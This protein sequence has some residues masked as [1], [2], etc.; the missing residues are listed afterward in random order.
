M[1]ANKKSKKPVKKS[2]KPV[3][4]TR[5][6]AKGKVQKTPAKGSAKTAKVSESQELKVRKLKPSRYQSFKMS[7]RIKHQSKPLPSAFKLL[8]STFKQ[9]IKNWRLFGGITLIYI[10]LNI[11]LVKSLGTGNNISELKGTLQSAFSGSAANIKTSLTLF[12]TLLSNVGSSDSSATSTYQTIVLLI[13]S[14]VLIWALRQ[15]TTEKKHVPSVRDAFY[16][17]LYPLVPFVLVIIVIELQFIPLLIANFLG[18]AV[19]GGGLAVT[20]IEKTLWILLCIILCI[21]SFYMVASSLFAL[22]IVTLP[23]LRPMAALRSARELVRYRR[24]VVL[25]KIFFLPLAMLVIAA[26]IM[27]PLIMWVPVLAQWVFFALSMVALAVFHGYMY[28]LYRALL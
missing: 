11:V 28:N 1:A 26:I 16:K 18:N 12:G 6:T 10:V 22:Y 14:L 2:S 17:G 15:T 27:V 9:L 24:L 7:R 19:L 21:L 25:R 8:K 4:G 13:V 23:D 5:L 20:S 3:D